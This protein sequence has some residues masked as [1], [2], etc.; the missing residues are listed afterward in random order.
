MVK[1]ITIMVEPEANYSSTTDWFSWTNSHYCHTISLPLHHGQFAGRISDLSRQSDVQ[2]VLREAYRNMVACKW[3]DS[4][5]WQTCW[6]IGDLNQVPAYSSQV[7]CT[8]ASMLNSSSRE[9]GIFENGFEEDRGERERKRE[10]VVYV[11]HKQKE[12]M[13]F[14]GNGLTGSYFWSILKQKFTIGESLTFV[15][16]LAC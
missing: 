14:G 4:V 2:V 9:F 13:V 16:I 7:I 15:I 8:H 5:K 11:L 12:R 10:R 6:C 1:Q 3:V